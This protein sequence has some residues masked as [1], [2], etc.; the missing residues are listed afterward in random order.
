MTTNHIIDFQDCLEHSKTLEADSIALTVT[1][2]PYPCVSMWDK[3]LIKS[4]GIYEQLGDQNYLA[5]SE[6]VNSRLFNG[7]WRELY[8]VTIEGG[9]VA[10][11]IGESVRNSAMFGFMAVPN[12][13]SIIHG[14]LHA[15]FIPMP[16]IIWSKPSNSTNKFMGSG[17]L[18]ASAYVTMEHEHILLFRKG[19]NRAFTTKQAKANRRESGFFYWERNVWFSDIW[20]DVNGCIQDLPFPIKD[21]ERSGAFPIEIPYRLINMFSVKGD[22]VYDPFTGLGNTLIAAAMSQRSSVGCEIEPEL[23]RNIEDNLYRPGLLDT[24]NLTLLRRINK[25]VYNSSLYFKDKEPKHFNT[26]HHLPVVSSQETDIKILPIESVSDLS[27]ESKIIFDVTY[28]E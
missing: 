18:P 22:T 17:M 28:Q 24:L 20:D 26:Y 6:A 9:W 5:A 1:S 14:M 13:A 12:H 27:S 11:N 7:L 8:R 21:R 2:P 4:A 3:Q 23:R 10:I 15:G 16:S 25:A 19:S